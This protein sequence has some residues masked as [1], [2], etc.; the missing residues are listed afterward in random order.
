[1]YYTYSAIHQTVLT[2][3]IL[4]EIRLGIFNVIFNIYRNNIWKLIALSNPRS[5]LPHDVWYFMV[6]SYHENWHGNND[7]VV[8]S[9]ALNEVKFLIVLSSSAF[10]NHLYFCHRGNRYIIVFCDVSVATIFSRLHHR[11]VMPS[12]VTSSTMVNHITTVEVQCLNMR[13][14]RLLAR[15]HSDDKP[16]RRRLFH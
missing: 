10:C 7:S 8:K 6:N 2:V 5:I 13:M 11:E 14:H 4:A 15:A 9:F 1:M 3:V 16:S 12:P